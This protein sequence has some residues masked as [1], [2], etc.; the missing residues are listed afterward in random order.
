M[1]RAFEET[2]DAAAYQEKT[3]I[4]MRMI[5]GGKLRLEEIAQYTGLPIEKVQE[6]AG[7]VVA[8]AFLCFAAFW[9]LKNSGKRI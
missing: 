5:E 2:R 1:C 4:A 3:D 8:L 6:L 9:A 7:A